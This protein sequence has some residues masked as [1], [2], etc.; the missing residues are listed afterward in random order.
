MTRKGIN[1]LYLPALAMIY[2]RLAPMAWPMLR[3]AA[4]LIM[5]P[6]GI[7]KLFGSFAPVLA[8]NVLAP[9]GLPA[10][11]ALA[12]FLGALEIFGGILFAAGILTRLLALMFAVE[13][14]IILV[15]VSLPKGWIYSAPGGGAEFPGLLFVLY[16]AFVFKGAGGCSIDGVL[17]H[18]L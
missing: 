13:T 4:G 2:D 9:I 16:L 7:P 6:H 18:E 15:F 5:I 14:A 11:L 12:Y 10:P 1:R 17:K 3:I 8:K